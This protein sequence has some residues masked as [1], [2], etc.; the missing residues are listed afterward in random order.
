MAS[1][2]ITE[3]RRGKVMISNGGVILQ[4]RNILK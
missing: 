1:Q 2:E 3:I 4:I